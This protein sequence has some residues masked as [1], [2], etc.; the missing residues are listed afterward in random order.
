MENPGKKVSLEG[1]PNLEAEPNKQQ[2]LV[3]VVVVVV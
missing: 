1:K 2:G 3:V